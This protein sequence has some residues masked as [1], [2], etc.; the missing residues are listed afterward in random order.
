MLLVPLAAAAHEP[1]IQRPPATAQAVGALHT[2]RQVPEACIRIE[3]RFSGRGD[4]PYD[5]RLVRTGR[6]CQPRAT[7]LDFAEVTPGEGGWKLNDRIRVPAADCPGQQAVVEVWRRQAE[8][9]LARDGQGQVRVYLGE[10]RQQ[11]DAGRLAALP[12]FA[13]KMAVQGTPCR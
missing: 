9:P 3:G 12:A 7:W 5:M 10:A 11:A 2:V 6:Q 4:A 1:E 13:V 8:Q